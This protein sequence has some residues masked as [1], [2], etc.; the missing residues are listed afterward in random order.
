[1]AVVK[2]QPAEESADERTD[3]PSRMVCMTLIDCLPG[4]SARAMNPATSPMMIN[5]MMVPSR[6]LLLVR[7]LNGRFTGGRG[8]TWFRQVSRVLLQPDARSLSS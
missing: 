2:Q 4:T 7:G 1:V 5:P 3:D 8:V 6:S